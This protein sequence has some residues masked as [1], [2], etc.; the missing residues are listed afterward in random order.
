M[1]RRQARRH[2]NRVARERPRLIDRP[3]RGDH[4]HEVGAAAVSPDGQPAADDLAER[5][6]IGPDAVKLLRPAARGAET[7]H[8]LVEDQQRAVRRGDLA[9]PGEE[10]VGRRDHAHVPG[11]RLDNDGGDPRT[12]VLKNTV[13]DFQVVV[14]RGERRRR[15]ARRNAG[16]IRQAQRRH[17]GAC[18]HE[19]RVRMPVIAAV[20][21]QQ[22]FATGRRAGQADRA[23]HRLS[24]G[25]NHPHFLDGGDARNDLASQL[26]LQRRRRPEARAV[27]TRQLD[28]FDD[29][30][31]G[32]AENR[33]PPRTD[34]IDVVATIDVSQTAASRRADVSRRSADGVKRTDRRI[35]AARHQRFGTFEKL[36]GLIHSA[37]APDIPLR[38]WRSR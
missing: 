18:L 32:V 3:G 20:E 15:S 16:R 29:G 30:R 33:R 10:S 22:L 4:V 13:D 31:M 38:P 17:P 21:F 1:Q 28:G 35:D 26:D 36:F 8:D 34:V 25:V 5:R 14:R 19:H 23:H 6:Q 2:C 37:I 7:G 11:D 9:K 24:A 27:L 12:V